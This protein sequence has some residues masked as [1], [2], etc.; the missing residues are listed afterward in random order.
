VASSRT[1]IVAGAGIGGLT[2]ALALV[3]KGFRAVVLEQAP[4][5]DETGA[6]IQLSPNATRI[7]IALGLDKAVA[8]S[9]VVPHFI[10]VRKARSG[11]EI[12]QV[13]L[14]GFAER[15]YGAPYWL[16]HRG[17]LQ[18]ILA[19]AARAHPDITLRLADR[20]E[21]F[22]VHANGVTV[23]GRHGQQTFEERGLAVVGA[24]GLWST[25]RARLGDAAPPSFGGRTAWRALVPANLVAP[26][27]REPVVE[28]WLG[29]KTHLVH[30][31]VKAGALVNVVAIVRDSWEK[32][33]WNEAGKRHEILGHFLPRWWAE[34][35]RALLGTPDNWLKW[36]LYDR[37]PLRRWG[38]GPITLIGDAA[39]PMLPF[40]AQ[41]A[42]LAIEDAAVLAECLSQSDDP[43]AG[44][45]RYEKWRRGRTAKAQR[46]ARKNGARYHMAGPDATVRNL[47]LRWMGG[48]RLLAHYDWLYDWRMD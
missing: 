38:E 14:G 36:A 9:A 17:D 44:M 1:V 28:L 39:H 37:L 19:D 33:G 31:P 15:R 21:D 41:G 2:A 32:P 12:V 42:A 35:A 23:A 10:R 29:W 18:A 34:P 46:A 6:G 40:L 30:Y 3:A 13:P 22:A 26:E 5:L 43:V 8:P 16:L 27:C 11:N 48:R 25:L 4:R 24:D 45:R 47:V 20:V 7:L